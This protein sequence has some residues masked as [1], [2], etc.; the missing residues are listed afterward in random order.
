MR[1]ACQVCDVHRSGELHASLHSKPGEFGPPQ[2]SAQ[3][4]ILVLQDYSS[5]Q[6]RKV[7]VWRVEPPP[8]L[9][10]G[11]GGHVEFDNW[12]VLIATLARMFCDGDEKAASDRMVLK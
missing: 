12:K 9:E 2:G 7:H 1:G 6:P 8:E 10:S 4:K 11:F 3:I 5:G